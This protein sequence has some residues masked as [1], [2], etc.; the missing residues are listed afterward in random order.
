MKKTY[1]IYLAGDSTVEDVSPEHGKKQGWGQ[2]LHP[3]FTKKVRIFNKA[4]GGRSTKSFMDEGRLH[5]II[6]LLQKGDYL[7]IQFGHNDQKIEDASRGTEPFTTYQENLTNYIIQA[8]DK[9]AIPILV[10]PVNR[11]VFDERGKLIDTLGEYPEA[12]RQLAALLHVPLIDL[13]QKSKQLYEKWGAE[14]TKKLFAW[15]DELA[16]QTTPPDD[17]HFSE[18]GAKK[19]AELVVESIKELE[20]EISKCLVSRIVHL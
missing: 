2:Q 7:F 1:T 13:N 14:E 17:T 4:K 10:T 20:L 19:M 12:M 3:F 6:N 11:R 15:Y 18:Y 16:L 8:R 5:E 9:G